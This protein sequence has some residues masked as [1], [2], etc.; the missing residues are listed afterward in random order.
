ML[1]LDTMYCDKC[2]HYTDFECGFKKMVSTVMI[3]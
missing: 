1:S 2:G 3:V